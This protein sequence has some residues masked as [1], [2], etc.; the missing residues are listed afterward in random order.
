VV[1]VYRPLNLIEALDIR[2]NE[3]TIVFAGGTDLM[4]KHRE[5]SGAVPKFSTSLLF[6]GHLTELQTINID[7]NSLKIGAACTLAQILNDKRIPDYLK[8]PI[9]QMASPSIRNMGTIGGNIGN[10]S[11]AGDTLPMLYALDAQL[12]IQ[13]KSKTYAV[14]IEDFI[15]GPG[16]NLLKP[17]EILSEITIPLSNY[18]QYYYRKVGSRK[19]NC[20]SKIS[21]F[22]LANGDAAQ[23][24]EVRIAFGAVAPTVIRSFEAET[25]LKGINKSQISERLND[26][27]SSYANL[28]NP[29]DD[30]RSTKIYRQKVSLQLLENFLLKELVW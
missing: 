7:N 10:S 20:I 29:V 5:W 18:R 12:T 28:L 9:A 30:R 26:I 2:N 13:S 6:I 25:L 16:Q 14:G 27:K 17:D 22:A 4:V 3:N 21:F 15:T 19:A 11:P 24:H 8:L 1:K 23:I